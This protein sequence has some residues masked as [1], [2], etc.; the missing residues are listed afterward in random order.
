MKR[1]RE[2]RRRT[3]LRE[4]RMT[5]PDARSETVRRR[6]AEQVQRL[7]PGSEED[8]LAWIEDVSEFDEHASR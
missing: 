3:G 6:V 2:R 1:M 8:A 4:I 5:V 7:D